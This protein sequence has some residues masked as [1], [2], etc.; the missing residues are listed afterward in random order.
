MSTTDETPPWTTR[1]Y[2]SMPSHTIGHFRFGDAAKDALNTRPAICTATSIRFRD[3]GIVA[4]VS[5]TVAEYCVRALRALLYSSENGV[6]TMGTD[7]PSDW[8]WQSM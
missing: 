3:A 5:G 8:F 6:P 4:P 1:P 2:A 7:S